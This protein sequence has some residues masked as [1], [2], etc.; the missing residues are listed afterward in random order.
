MANKLYVGSLSYD[1]TKEALIE[2]FSQAG[3]ILET[4]NGEKSVVLII[5]NFTGRPK[6]FGFVEMANAEAAQKAVEMFDGY[7]LDGWKILVNEA[8]PMKPRTEGGYRGGSSNNSRPGGSSY[9]GAPRSGSYGNT[10]PGGN[11]SGGGSYDR[12]NRSR[13]W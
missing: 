7:E 1:T 12:D 2:L 3:P 5:D 6:G 8:R 9:G 10:R 11:T 4:E 13:D